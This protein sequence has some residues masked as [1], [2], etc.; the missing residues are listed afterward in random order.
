MGYGYNQPPFKR[1]HT[2]FDKPTSDTSLSTS[3]GA[4]IEGQ[5]WEFPDV[6]PHTGA[7]R[8]NRR[9]KCMAVR[10][11]GDSN[12]SGGG[13]AQPALPR[14]LVVL[15][16]HKTTSLQGATDVGGMLGLCRASLQ[17]RVGWSTT[18]LPSKCVV[19]DE[20]LPSAGVAENDIFWAVIEGPTEVETPDAQFT[21]FGVGD[22]L[23]SLTQTT[24]AATNGTT[25]AGRAAVVDVATT[26]AS[27]VTLV[28]ALNRVFGMALTNCTSQ[29]YR[30]AILCDVGPLRY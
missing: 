20:Y 29:G 12:N 22:G 10:W 1:G 17:A 6:N 14:Q 19:V 8:S 16:A 7:V 21:A 27:T 15:D 9:V 11:T 4:N 18:V 24:A 28:G 3:D 23:V 2:L 30:Q 13:G 26:V 5:V 25:V